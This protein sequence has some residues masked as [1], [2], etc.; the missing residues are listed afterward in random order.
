MKVRIDI[1]TYYT[2]QIDKEIFGLKIPPVVFGI[3]Y[4]R[5]VENKFLAKSWYIPLSAVTI[6]DKN[7][8]LQQ[9]LQNVLIYLIPWNSINYDIKEVYSECL[10]TFET[11]A[12]GKIIKDFNTENFIEIGYGTL[13]V[14][15][16]E[17]WEEDDFF[18]EAEYNFGSY[19][20]SNECGISTRSSGNIFL[21][22]NEYFS[23]TMSLLKKLGDLCASVKSHEVITKNLDLKI[24]HTT[25]KLEV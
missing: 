13:M 7:D 10:K 11:M 24:E 21:N 8:L 14:E 22:K 18:L 19:N 3:N 9:K 12:E 6:T 23:L 20:L 1:I 4:S 17:S 2:P 25:E 15:K 5:S 16:N